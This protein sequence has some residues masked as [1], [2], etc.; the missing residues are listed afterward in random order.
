MAATA[1]VVTKVSENRAGPKSLRHQQTTS[2]DSSATNKG[3][4]LALY[5]DDNPTGE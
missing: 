3:K 1:G 2:R 5:V 4:R